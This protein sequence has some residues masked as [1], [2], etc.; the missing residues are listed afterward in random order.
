MAKKNQTTEINLSAVIVA[1]IAATALGP[2]GKA[3][4][5]IRLM[6]GANPSRIAH[7][8]AAG[9]SKKYGVDVTPADVIRA[10]RSAE[11]T[12]VLSV[13]GTGAVRPLRV[14]LAER[15]SAKAKRQAAKDAFAALAPLD[16][17]IA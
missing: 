5:E 9:V 4:H 17:E 12:E 2:L 6:D 8:I 7:G 11:S 1:S 14:V 10:V 16:V 3:R 13:N 15:E